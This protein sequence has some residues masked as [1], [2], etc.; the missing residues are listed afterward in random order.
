MAR[1]VEYNYEMCIEICDLVRNGMN[2]K[3]ALTLKK[4]Y[5]VFETWCNWKRAN[6][7]LLDLYVK[8]IQDKAES[9]DEMID[10]IADDLRNKLIDPASANVLIQTL[11]WKASKYYPKMFGE[12]STLD[13]GGSVTVVNVNPKEWVE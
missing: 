9:V 1:P 7:E 11:K 12:N 10:D 4:E 13:L 5:P 3:K 2:I 8:S 6:N